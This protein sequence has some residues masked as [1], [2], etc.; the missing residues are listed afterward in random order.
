MS[1]NRDFAHLND[2][3]PGDI[4]R[5]KAMGDIEGALR[6]I[7]ARL[8]GGLQPE[9][10]PRL[11]VEKLR[12]E[13]LG[14]D[15]SLSRPEALAA[16]RC[17][18]PEVTEEQFDALV[19]G[20]RIDWR[21]VDGEVKY[22]DR[23]VSS[24]RLYPRLTPGMKRGPE[25]G[26][27]ERDAVLARM[28]REGSL[29]ARITVKASI[30]PAEG[31]AG[32]RFQAWLPIPAACPQQS[33]IEIL[34]AAPGGVCAPEDVPQ[35][36]IWWPESD[37]REFFVTYR[38][39]HRAVYTD[40]MTIV[41]DPVQPDFDLGEEEPHLVFT[42]QLRALTAR[43]TEGCSGPVE[44]AGAIYDYITEY[45]DYRFQPA[46]LQLDCIADRCATELRGDCGVMALLFIA[47][48]R[49]AGIP[50]R[51]QSGLAVR[52]GDVGCHD[53]AMFYIAPHG[54]LW[55]DCS[56]GSAARRRG[57][58]ARRKHYFGNLDPWRMVANRAF[59]AALTPPDPEWRSD[60]FDNQTGELIA[61]GVGLLGRQR[62][63]GQELIEFCWADGE[64]E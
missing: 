52:P 30:R 3:L 58:K 16:L 10:A 39:L 22:H 27:E 13:R 25:T 1:K 48:C 51:W 7:D 47:M 62:V 5:R 29:T 42:P 4:A 57:E 9:L 61:D 60:P 49:I 38:Y 12:L 6:L 37:C 54:W 56:Y 18:W 8:A 20:G 45:V 33:E 64:N 35:R 15:Y 40:P 21:C 32:S 41:P 17:E 53:W 34:D 43:V 36:T 23:F 31:V 14:A 63:T 46:Y 2:L 11:R 19:D 50:A 59:F 28:Q 24:L 44:K 55:A 26:T